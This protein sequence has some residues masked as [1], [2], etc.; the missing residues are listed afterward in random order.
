MCLYSTSDSCTLHLQVS[1]LYADPALIHMTDK[2]TEVATAVPLQGR[3]PAFCTNVFQE[4]SVF[5]YNPRDKQL[6]SRT[7]S[8]HQIMP[9]FDSS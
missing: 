7:G 9:I 8:E 6:S 3:F 2:I 5:L 1:F 4:N